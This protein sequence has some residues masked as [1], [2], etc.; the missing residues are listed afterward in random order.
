MIFDVK[1]S[2]YLSSMKYGE[3]FSVLLI[4]RT[5]AKID[6]SLPSMETSEEGQ[7]KIYIKSQ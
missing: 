2:L 3:I 7:K 6:M 5:L 4:S 1:L